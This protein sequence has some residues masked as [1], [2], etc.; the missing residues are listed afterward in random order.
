MLVHTVLMGSRK[1]ITVTISDS[2]PAPPF[3]YSTAEITGTSTLTVSSGT[4]HSLLT[5]FKYRPKVLSLIFR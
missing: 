4:S 2:A 5:A 3:L 1:Y